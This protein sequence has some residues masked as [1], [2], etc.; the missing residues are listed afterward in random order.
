M[1][2]TTIFKRSK[3]LSIKKEIMFTLLYLLIAKRE[4]N[5]LLSTRISITEATFTEL[6]A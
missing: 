2:S 4:M 5:I 3:T 1:D 6:C